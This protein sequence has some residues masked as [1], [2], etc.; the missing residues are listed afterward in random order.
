M[1]SA[2]SYHRPSYS[3]SGEHADHE[4]EVCYIIRRL[5][6]A[7]PTM[8]HRVFVCVSAFQTGKRDW[9]W[10]LPAGLA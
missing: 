2:V 1:A 8:A 6:L 9:E 3:Q 5:G 10:F 7:D 4:C